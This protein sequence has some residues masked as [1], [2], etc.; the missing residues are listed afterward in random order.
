ANSGA[1]GCSAVACNGL[2]ISGSSVYLQASTP[3]AFDIGDEIVSKPIKSSPMTGRYQ[4]N[5]RCQTA[6]C[7]GTRSG[8][9]EALRRVDPDVLGRP[10]GDVLHP[11]RRRARVPDRVAGIEEVDLVADPDLEPAAEDHPP[12][13]ALVGDRLVAE[14]GTDLVAAVDRLD[15]L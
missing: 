6:P 12:L 4:R 5:I 11:V 8:R 14:A 1:P 2:A 15:P 10:V 9:L 7:G 13:L 3:K